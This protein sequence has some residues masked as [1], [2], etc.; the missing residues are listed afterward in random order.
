MNDECKRLIETVKQYIDDHARE[1]FTIEQLAE[2]FP[3]SQNRLSACF[4]VLYGITPKCY[5]DEKKMDALD[6]LLL[7]EGDGYIMMHYAHA[8]GLNDE[9][10]LCHLV[11]RKRG[12]TFSEYKRYLFGE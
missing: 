9:S 3:V 8:I 6:T 4:K 5:L 1:D 10:A 2:H 11:R 12:M 7:T